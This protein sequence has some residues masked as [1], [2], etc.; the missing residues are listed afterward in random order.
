MLWPNTWET[1]LAIDSQYI[2]DK[3]GEP[4]DIKFDHIT[5]QLY[6]APNVFKYP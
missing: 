3:L 1:S 5:A 4:Y 6:C 2:Q